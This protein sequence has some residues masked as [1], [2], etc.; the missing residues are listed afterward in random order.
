MGIQQQLENRTIMNNLEKGFMIGVWPYTIVRAGQTIFGS[1]LLLHLGLGLQLAEKVIR[2]NGCCWTGED[3]DKL[4]PKSV[5]KCLQLWWHECPAGETGV[6][7]HRELNVPWSGVRAAEDLAG[8]GEATVPLQPHTNKVS[9][10]VN[11]NMREQPAEHS[12]LNWPSEHKTT[13]LLLHFRLS[14]LMHNVSCIP[15]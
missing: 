6:F 3:K 11:R 8:T 9:Q 2:K 12:G 5:S 7:Q 13:S 14:D 1:L 10:Q 4:E 15:R